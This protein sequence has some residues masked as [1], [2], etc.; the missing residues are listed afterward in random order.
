MVH[1]TYT[2]EQQK[3]LFENAE[4]HENLY[5]LTKKYNEVFGLNDSYLRVKSFCYSENLKTKNN[6]ENKK[7]DYT[8]EEIN[9]LKENRSKVKNT[10]ELTEKY[11]KTFDVKRTYGSIVRVCSEHKIRR[12]GYREI[13]NNKEYDE[14]IKENY[15]KYSTKEMVELVKD[16]FGIDTSL[17]AIQNKIN[18]FGLKRTDKYK[19]HAKELGHEYTYRQSVY[20]KVKHDKRAKQSQ[21]N[22][23]RKAN[24]M[25][26]QYHNTKIDDKTHIVVCVDQNIN[27][28]EKEN[29]L[30]LTIDEY[31]RWRSKKQFYEFNDK[32]HHEA[33]LNLVRLETLVKKGKMA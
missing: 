30:L 3:W 28:F 17:S 9:W 8:E 16:M 32:Q 18:R 2:E 31:N 15:D 20:I 12:N 26:E 23:R 13:I 21:L 14:W 7:R 11:N 25:Y 22:Y 4:K 19:F 6:F 10:K 33:F 27:N 29:L 1:K 24:V 5:E